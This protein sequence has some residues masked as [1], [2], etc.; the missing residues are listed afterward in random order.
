VGRLNGRRDHRRNEGNEA[1]E[2]DALIEREV[3]L[4]REESGKGERDRGERC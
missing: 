2:R 3:E 4:E 1:T